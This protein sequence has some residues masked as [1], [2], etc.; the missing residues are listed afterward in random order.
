MMLE[1]MH[2]S[3]YLELVKLWKKIDRG[4]AQSAAAELDRTEVTV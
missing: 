1:M 3:W 2:D 4:L